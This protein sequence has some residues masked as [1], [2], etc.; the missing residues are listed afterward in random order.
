[1]P[2]SPLR[3]GGEACKEAAAARRKAEAREGERARKLE[4]VARGE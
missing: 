2:T 1:M 4:E 3:G